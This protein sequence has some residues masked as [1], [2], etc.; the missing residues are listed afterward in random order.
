MIQKTPDLQTINS[1]TYQLSSDIPYTGKFI[2]LHDNRQKFYEGSYKNG[3][4]EGVWQ[5][6]HA[7]GRASS[8]GMYKNGERHGFWTYWYS[9]KTF[10]LPF[11]FK[12]CI[13]EQIATKMNY[14]D[15]VLNGAC[16]EW[17]SNGVKKLEKGF[18]YGF[19]NG[20]YIGW[21][22]SGHKK[23][24]GKYIVNLEKNRQH[25]TGVWSYWNED[26]RLTAKEV[27]REGILIGELV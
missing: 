18:K 11:L 15:G 7:N 2:V 21:H 25:K 4:R 1:I 16:I 26:G 17:H 12:G 8:E 19:E 14:A 20:S 13:E 23:I 10:D 6:W 24:E 3:K 9:Q 22:A 27:Y 5:G